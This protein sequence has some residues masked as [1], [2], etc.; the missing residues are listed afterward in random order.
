[1]KAAARASARKRTALQSAARSKFTAPQAVGRAPLFLQRTCACGGGCPRC[2]QEKELKAGIQAKLTV[3]TPGDAYEQEADRIADQVVRNSNP[4]SLTR[5][6]LRVDDQ[7]QR[8]S[9]D[10]SFHGS[11]ASQVIPAGGGTPLAQSQRSFYESRLGHDFSPVRIHTGAIADESARSV[12]ASA[13]TV[14]RD[15]VFGAGQY[16]PDTSEGQKLLAHELTHV[17]QQ[18]AAGPMIQRQ[19][20]PQ[21]ETE[22]AEPTLNAAPGGLSTPPRFGDTAADPSCPAAPTRLGDLPPDPPCPQS[23]EEIDGEKFHFCKGSDIFRPADDRTRLI[24]FARSRPAHTTFTVHGYASQEGTASANLN[25]SCHRAKRAERELIN[26]GVRQESIRIAAKG[27]TSRFNAETRQQARAARRVAGSED[28]FAANRVAVVEAEIQIDPEAEA[29]SGETAPHGS[30]AWKRGIVE[31]ARARIATGDYNLAADAYLSTW[32]CGTM[33]SFTEAIRRVTIRIEGEDRFAEIDR[34]LPDPSRPPHD[35]RLGSIPVAR[36]DNIAQFSGRNEMILSNEIFETSD[37]AGCA[38]ARILDMTFHHMV[39]GVVPVNDQHAAGMFAVALAGFG[40]CVTP[41][42][43]D[44]LHPS[45]VMIPGSTWAAPVA[46]DPR[47]RDVP[48]LPGTRRPCGQALPGPV[49]PEPLPSGA[50]RPVSFQGSMTMASNSGTIQWRPDFPNNAVMASSPNGSMHA[51]GTATGSG[52]PADL[53]HYRVGFLQSIIEEERLIDY[54]RGNRVQMNLPVP[55]RDGPPRQLDAP[56]WFLPPTVQTP[57]PTTHTASADLSDSPSMRVDYTFVNEQFTG[58]RLRQPDDRV[59]DTGNVLNRASS[60]VVFNTW[61]VARDERAPLTAS[62]THFL[63]GRS[64]TWTQNVDVTGTQGAGTFTADVSTSPP[65]DFRLMQLTGP[66]AA[67]V[68]SRL[69]ITAVNAPAPRPQDA[70][71]TARESIQDFNRLVLRE[72]QGLEPYRR[73]LGLTGEL[74]VRV[75]ID[76]QTGRVSIQT[77]R[78][79]ER[80][81]GSPPIRTEEPHGPA[82]NPGNLGAFSDALLTRLRKDAVLPVLQG[83]FSGLVDI[84]TNVPAIRAVPRPQDPFAAAGGVGLVQAINEAQQEVESEQR[85]AQNPGVYDPAFI[86][87]VSVRMLSEEYLYDFTIPG[88]ELDSVCQDLRALGCVNMTVSRADNYGVRIV[89]AVQSLNNTTYYSPIEIAL[90]TFAV[91][92]KLHMPR[93]NPASVNTLNH[94]LNH[95]VESYTLAQ[96]FKDRLAR[97]VRNRLVEVRREAA[98]HPNLRDVLLSDA[99]IREIVRQEREPLENAFVA[100]WNRRNTP[101]DERDITTRPVI[102]GTWRNFR[103]P[104]LQSGATGSFVVEPPGDQSP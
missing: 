41:P 49:Q 102:P 30:M 58:R 5:P 47:A 74:V 67:E 13:F 50:R 91:R 95:L 4:S 48:M 52:D 32:S 101:I 72:V 89:R 38:A 70:Q 77:P 88:I 83:S 79:S 53:A 62:S 12:H 14:G 71:H 20:A 21:G 85:R 57:D 82:G 44:P 61:L 33:P 75:R 17:V 9:G 55:I 36:V 6:G 34:S 59:I 37:P 40:A 26:A 65:A 64:I 43:M 84:P 56:P 86:P 15:I 18:R 28:L 80:A 90:E 2:E 76:L 7:V 94:E 27:Q 81:A 24:D 68:D 11:D 3:N 10:E 25:L 103:M 35:P 98:E 51:T 8:K 73:L 22:V 78:T 69:K 16:A 23:T 87:P 66:T 1:M 31:Q 54:V 46:Q 104:R 42:S 60:R 100:E 96:N 19:E 29:P 92:F 97:A 45:T 39:R 99:S 93:E 63:D